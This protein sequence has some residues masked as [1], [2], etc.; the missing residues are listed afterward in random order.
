M[1]FSEVTVN[2]IIIGLGGTGCKIVDSI[3]SYLDSHGG[4][5]ENEAF[6]F[7]D[8][9]ETDLAGLW[10]NVKTTQPI[11]YKSAL[12]LPPKNI[13]MQMNPWL[14]E[15][16]YGVW[17]QG[18]VGQRRA[19]GKALYAV[20][21]EGIGGIINQAA[22]ELVSKTQKREFVIIL[23][24][25][26]GGGTG[27]GIVPD[28]SLDIKNW[29]Q[30]FENAI[31]FGIGILPYLKQEDPANIGNAM[32]ALKEVHFLLSLKERRDRYLNPFKMF[33]LVGRE[34]EG[35]P[36][37]NTLQETILRF[38][39]DLGFAPG[40]FFVPCQACGK[41][42]IEGQCPDGHQQ[43]RLPNIQEGGSPR[44]KWFDL[45][46]LLNRLA[47][48]TSSFS[49][50]GYQ[51]IVFPANKI[52][53]LFDTEKM[54]KELDEKSKNSQVEM[55]TIK[56]NIQ[57]LENQLEN[58]K[59]V[60]ERLDDD[61][62]E[63]EITQ[64]SFSR[65]KIEEIRRKL[66][67]VK[68][69]YSENCNYINDLNNKLKDLESE[70]INLN[71]ERTKLVAYKEKFIQEITTPPTDIYNLRHMRQIAL[72]MNEI[73]R[74]KE[75]ETK[76]NVTED[77]LV[78]YFK[79][80]M[81]ELRRDAEY[82]DFVHKPF[83]RLQVANRPLINYKHMMK[84]GDKED[85]KILE[86]LDNR[87][88]I[89]IDQD[90][91]AIIDEES[92]IGYVVSI[93][94]TNKLNIDFG[95]LGLDN[96][97][98]IL[99]ATIAKQAQSFPLD[100]PLDRFRVNIYNLMIGLHPW[101][102]APGLPSRLQDL[103]G[104]KTIYDKSTNEEMLLHHSLF[105]GNFQAFSN[106]TGKQRSVESVVKFWKNYDIVD[107]E[108]KWSRVPV[109]IAE[110]LTKI[111]ELDNQL[112]LLIQELEVL[113]TLTK[114]KEELKD[115]T[116]VGNIRSHIHYVYADLN[117]LASSLNKYENEFNKE[118]ECLSGVISQL[119]SENIDEDKKA[120][121][122]NFLEHVSD[123]ISVVLNKTNEVGSLLS[124]EVP[125]HLQ[126]IDA[127]IK[128]IPLMAPHVKEDIFNIRK[129]IEDI[130]PKSPDIGRNLL[131]LGVPLNN[132]KVNID[133]L[134]RRLH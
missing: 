23:V 74:F 46:D 115:S 67:I 6:I 5:P 134:S 1:V 38:L 51:S 93:I 82:E 110:I 42:L 40:L 35:I 119:D 78:S 77:G 15:W 88:F 52:L 97:K 72:N 104:L 126:E 58:I 30:N 108:V 81:N 14:P 116:M 94:S 41:R 103:D 92:K 8:S 122:R 2:R 87:G 95:K 47:P 102:P 20:H 4:I 26:L 111:D 16:I 24:C 45:N 132:I 34:I 90:T 85:P 32:A 43:D 55:V 19:L 91:G 101:A 60:K 12:T 130:R 31:I 106:L 3:A 36:V 25:A 27:S 125:Q 133:T 54:I 79:E 75:K 69:Q 131:Q 121:I 13:L 50:I 124:S 37:D 61:V 128:V 9:H 63:L 118:K 11:M 100:V 62:Y 68:S 98:I 129:D 71:K 28:L 73:N 21:K 10:Q 80:I 18:G 39:V 99:E 120:N 114:K 59:I 66:E 65:N 53:R 48:Y 113:D 49:T 33:I 109:T 105:L 64:S 84:K 96:V 57:G 22:L 86:I 112:S 17:M 107:K 29:M 44:N 56:E 70:I 76:L 83:Q 123:R 127:S 117:K 89:E 7:I